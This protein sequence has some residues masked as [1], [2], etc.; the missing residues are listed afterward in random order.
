MTPT[1]DKAHKSEMAT[2]DVLMHTGVANMTA[3]FVPS[4]GQDRGLSLSSP[5]AG[6]QAPDSCFYIITSIPA[7]SIPR[8]HQVQLCALSLGPSGSY[9]SSVSYY[10]D[11]D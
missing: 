4:P 10:R 11:C 3:L 1:E 6:N 2:P 7:Q 9:V 8:R 5:E